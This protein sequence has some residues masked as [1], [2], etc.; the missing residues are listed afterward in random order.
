M[1]KYS[2][3]QI[4]ELLNDIIF[5]DYRNNPIILLDQWDK[6]GEQKYIASLH[7][8]YENILLDFN[9]IFPHRDIQNRVLEISSFLGVVD[10]ALSKIG[11]D[12]YTYDI[13]VFQ[14]N[15]NLN[16][17]YTAHG[18]HS[19]SG[20]V[21]DIGKNGLPFPDNH[22][23]A[24]ILSEV[25]EHVPVN[26]LPILQEINRI[27]KNN[28]IVYITTPNQVN[29]IHRILIIFGRSIRNPVSDLVTQTDPAKNTICGVHWREY[30]LQELTDLLK[31]AGFSVHEYTFSQKGQ[32]AEFTLKGMFFSKVFNILYWIFPQTGNSITILGKKDAST[33]VKFRSDDEFIKYYP[34]S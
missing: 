31:I 22:F 8:Q 15:S 12:V 19:S 28:G 5:S 16:R 10:I 27:L 13:P 30:T 34:T 9:R 20:S 24:V 29:L 3:N 18:V 4:K 21:K 26:P 7:K 1:M 32:Q 6:T 33:P 17:L 14:Q 11:F 23:D 2:D 25:L